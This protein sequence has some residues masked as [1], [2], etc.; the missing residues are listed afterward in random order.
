[1]IRFEESVRAALAVRDGAEPGWLQGLRR[2]AGER[3]LAQGLPTTRHEEWRYTSLAGL[4]QLAFE[5]RPAPASTAP[6]PGGE[7][8]CRLV[9][10]DGAFRPD[11]SRLAGL[12]P[13]LRVTSLAAALASEPDRLEARLARGGA[14]EEHPFGALALALARDGA[15]V[16]VPSGLKVSEPIELLFLH[17]GAEPR[18]AHYLSLVSAGEGSALTLLERHAGEGA[19]PTLTNSLLE[20]VAGPGAEVE[21]LRLQEE[22]PAAFH[23]GLLALRQDAKS[24]VASR[25]VSLGG[26][27]ARAETRA[28]LAGEG[29]ECVLDGLYLGRGRQLLDQVVHLDHQSPRCTSR[30][31]FKGIL[32]GESRGVFSGRIR[33]REGAQQTDADQVSSSL[34]LSDDAQADARPQLEILADD[35]KCSHGGA[36]GQL[37]EEALFYLRSRG[38]DRAQARS[39]LTYAFASELVERI[40]PAALRAAARRGVMARLPGGA[41]LAEAA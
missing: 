7:P 9:F 21:H 15:L 30:E 8:G 36:I 16:E 34:L 19:A 5:H 11:R 23:L 27:L 1:M 18:A 31:R 6:A 2:R 39:L 22:G 20:V 10:V 40:R 24:R 3:F 32:D 26:A 29:A 28:L 33:V 13:G 4:A 14:F 38:I 17:T 25:S 41:L 37:S 12:P 35:V